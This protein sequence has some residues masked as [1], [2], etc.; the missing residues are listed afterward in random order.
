MVDIYVF[1]S[2]VTTSIVTASIPAATAGVA[3]H[4]E[5]IAITGNVGAV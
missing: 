5:T 1:I 3:Q 4:G 2:I